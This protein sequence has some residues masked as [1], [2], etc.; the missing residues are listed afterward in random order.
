L[1]ESARITQ[2]I[3][4]SV[5]AGSLK[6]GD[7]RCGTGL[8]PKTLASYLE[9]LDKQGLITVAKR[10]K[11]GMSKP[12]S[13]TDA[14]IKWLINIP[15]NEN[16]QILLKIAEQLKKRSNREIFLK[17]N[18]KRHNQNAKIIQNYFIERNLK[19]DTSPIEY[20]EGVDLTDTDQPFREVLKKVLTLHMYLMSG[21]YQSPEEI[22]RELEKDFILFSP[23]MYFKFNWH[24]GS[25][26]ALEHQIREAEKTFERE[27]KAAGREKERCNK[28]THMLDLE[29]VDEED[30]EKYLNAT[31]DFRRKRI[32]AN[33]ECQEGW[34]V[35]KYIGKLFVG[36]EAEIAK[37]I[38]VQKRPF[39]MRFI[40]SFDNCN[41]K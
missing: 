30:Y 8:S 4:V 37:Y 7:I 14:G 24:P 39:L 35:G 9:H 40:S 1:D 11:R 17:T 33:I 27:S 20:P 41:R 25:F 19:G 12:C 26:P 38:D 36:K 34:S 3:L 2:K 13:I 5:L 10:K 22:E 31:S 32:L 16:L 21:P 28:V 29:N 15:L 6:V 18:A 23:K